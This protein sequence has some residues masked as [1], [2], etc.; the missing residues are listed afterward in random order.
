MSAR[1]RPKR[2]AHVPPA[3]IASVPVR[4]WMRQPVITIDPGKRV[5]GIVT[6]RD[7]RQ[8]MFDVAMGRVDEDTARL[9]E[10]RVREVMTWGVKRAGKYVVVWPGGPR[11]NDGAPRHD[12]EGTA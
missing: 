4:R 5:V 12:R 7:L 6:D 8:V 1:A 2:A 9:G 3:W 11:P 10:L